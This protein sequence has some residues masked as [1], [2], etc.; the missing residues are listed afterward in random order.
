MG[1]ID[2]TLL[3][4]YLL[5]KLSEEKQ[6]EV[7]DRAFA[8]AGYRAALEAAEADLIDEYVRGELPAGD[9]RAFESLFLASPQRRSKVEF[10]RALAA[11]PATPAPERP[12]ISLLDLFRGWSLPFRFAVAMAALLCVAGASWFLVHDANRQPAPQ[13]AQEQKQA[14]APVAIPART[15]VVASL[16]LFA[17]LSRAE[18]A[19]PQLVLSPD[20]EVVNIQLQLDDRDDYPEFRAELRTSRGEKIMTSG[21]LTRRKVGSSFAL[22]FDVPASVLKAGKYELAL[23]GLPGGE[24]AEDISYSYFS[25][26]RR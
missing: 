22:S 7:E 8:D 25:V 2:E 26:E 1:G 18:G 13:V 23:K 6:A 3:V 9:R 14:P 24:P 12:R 5:G 20:A 15:P 4:Q 17:G 10:A 11:V 19:G 16:V 21:A